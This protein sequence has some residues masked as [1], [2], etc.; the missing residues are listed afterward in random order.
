MGAFAVDADRIELCGKVVVIGGGNAAIDAART[1]LRL[2]AEEVTIVYRRT[3][4]QMP[5]Y[6]EEIDEALHEGVKLLDLTQPVEVV[7]DDK[8]RVC[9]LKCMQMQLGDF[10]RTGRRKPTAKA[11]DTF[12]IEADQ[13]I[14]A[15][16]QRL[17]TKSLLGSTE[18]ELNALGF[19]HVDPAT[20]Q[21]SVPW[22]F[23]GG[24]IVTG[25]ASVV[26][27]IA[28]GEKAAVG[29][30]QML[31]GEEHAFWRQDKP[32]MTSFD[33]DADP[34][35]YPREKVQSIPVERRKYNFDEVEQ[36]W[37]ES[38][39]IRQSKRCLRCDYGKNVKQKEEANA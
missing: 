15:L 21:T 19:I 31:T 3:Q 8:G 29:I 26:K 25:P 34:V 11:Q 37:I 33:P 35:P 17:D 12:L 13:V 9:A 32:V 23:A 4:D 36:P 10:D 39:A 30:D 16:G 28:A 18:V 1:A 5:A 38:V 14:L 6:A 22:I 7:K 20:G 2:E 27:A 24:D